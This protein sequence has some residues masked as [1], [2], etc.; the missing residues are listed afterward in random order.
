MKDS[1]L[2][3]F[4]KLNRPYFF[5]ELLTFL[6]DFLR[7]VIGSDVFKN[8]EQFENEALGMI[9]NIVAHD[10]EKS[11]ELKL[12]INILQALTQRT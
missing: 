4:Y 2:V 7:M 12:F 1:L 9:Y 6:S 11:K 10:S 3:E 5:E 8:K